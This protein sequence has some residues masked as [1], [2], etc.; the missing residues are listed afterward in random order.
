MYFIVK[1][2]KIISEKYN[3]R[4]TQLMSSTRISLGNAKLLYREN[5]TKIWKS[6]R[7]AKNGKMKFYKRSLHYEKQ[8]K[9]T[10]NR[11]QKST[12]R[13]APNIVLNQKNVLF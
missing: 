5:D 2:Y 12:I 1:I 4:G 10:Q 3:Q 9:S 8:T 7:K 11:N 13:D 6:V